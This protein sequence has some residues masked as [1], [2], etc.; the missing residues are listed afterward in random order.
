MIYNVPILLQEQSFEPTDLHG[1]SQD[2]KKTR[3]QVMEIW[4]SEPEEREIQNETT[5]CYEN[6]P[7]EQGHL[8]PSVYKHSCD[9]LSANH[10]VDG[11]LL[12]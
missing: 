8:D 4:A 9:I 2:S 12:F 5:L 1:L 11:K 6:A 10:Y 7:C 3:I